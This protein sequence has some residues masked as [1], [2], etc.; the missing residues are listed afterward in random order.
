MFSKYLFCIM[1][2][3]SIFSAASSASAQEDNLTDT[4]SA[5]GA[6]IET[7]LESGEDSGNDTAPA[8]LL[9]EEV[10]AVM[11]DTYAGEASAAEGCSMTVLP[12]VEDVYMDISEDMVYNDDHLVCEYLK[13]YGYE[14]DEI[15]GIAMVQFNITDLD[16]QEDDVAVLV[17]KGESMEKVGDGGVAVALMPIT[18]EWSENSSVT[19][20]ALNMLSI[21][22]MMSDG[23]DLDI[24]QMG[25]N[26]GSDEIFAFDVSE[27]LKAAEEDRISFLLMAIGDT[28]YRVSFKSRET[29][30]GPALLI[31][32]YPTVPPA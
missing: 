1:I 25:A 12:A 26:F 13:G 15:P 5:S 4:A 8:E 30:E 22:A 27:H 11:N 32:P 6:I 19:T 9:P 28:D 14:K 2:V 24:S 3:L 16:L 21:V 20:L 17:L 31:I 29:G 23:D 7:D 18:S 10:I